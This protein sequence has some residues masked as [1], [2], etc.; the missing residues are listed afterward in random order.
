LDRVIWMTA[1]NLALSVVVLALVIHEAT[2]PRI[3]STRAAPAG[4]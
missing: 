3:N 1:V 4:G 2:S